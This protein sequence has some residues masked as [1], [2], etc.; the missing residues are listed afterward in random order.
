MPEPRL[1]NAQ[2]SLSMVLSLSVNESDKYKL[3]VYLINNDEIPEK[4]VY[5]QRG[6]FFSRF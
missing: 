6:Q 3:F 4:N 1:L 5:T 2:T